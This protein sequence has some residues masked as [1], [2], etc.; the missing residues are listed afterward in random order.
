MG[1]AALKAGVRLRRFVN[2][3]LP[4]LRDKEYRQ[5]NGMSDHLD[6]FHH[7][8]DDA[9][10][11]NLGNIV[12]TSVSH[13]KERYSGVSDLPKEIGDV[14]PQYFMRYLNEH[15]DEILGEIARKMLEDAEYYKED[16]KALLDAEFKEMRQIIEEGYGN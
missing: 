16:A 13:Y 15:K 6:I 11:V 3:T 14:M 2:E 7:Q 12:F 4:Q 5:K 9:P 1:V 10:G 8:S